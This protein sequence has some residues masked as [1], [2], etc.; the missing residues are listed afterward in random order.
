[1]LKHIVRIQPTDP[2]LNCS[3]CTVDQIYCQI[4][5]LPIFLFCALCYSI[6]TIVLMYSVMI[7]LIFHHVVS[8]FAYGVVCC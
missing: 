1:M 7:P 8:C 6:F 5:G 4:L 2:E 3:S